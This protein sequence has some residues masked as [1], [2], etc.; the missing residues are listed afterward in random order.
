MR[1][2]TVARALLMAIV[3][4]AVAPPDAAAQL[5]PL[6]F[7]KQ[8]APNVIVVVDTA[9]RMQRDQDGNYRDPHV[10]TRTGAP[11]ERAIGIGDANTSSGGGYRRMY[12]NLHGAPGDGFTAD[13]ISTT[14]D[15]E[16]GYATFDDRTGI[17]IARRGVTE[18]I[19]RN[20]G[21]ARFGLVK[22]R[23]AANPVYDTNVAPVAVADAGQQ[24][25]TDGANGTWKITWPVVGQSNGSIASTPSPATVLVKPDEPGANALVNQVLSRRTGAAGSLTPAGADRTN[26]VDAPVDNMLDDA[27][28]EAR[29]LIDADT[30]CRNTVVVLVVAGGEGQTTDEDPVAKATQFLDV[31]Q[32]HR[33]PIYVIAIVPPVA[34][35]RT[36]RSMEALPIMFGSFSGSPAGPR[37]LSDD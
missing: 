37:G 12:V 10:Y 36:S 23:Q 7:L 19:D 3:G 33:V 13:R 17:G 27:K 35:T 20:F 29:R 26:V 34:R 24:A 4:L 2:M 16:T 32:H 5:D 9:N 11:Y 30:Q 31:S 15:R 25:E 8:K 22:M 1:A 6:L 28:A 21:V 14:G 18:A